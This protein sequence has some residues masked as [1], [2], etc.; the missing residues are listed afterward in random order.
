MVR[1]ALLEWFA[2]LD[3]LPADHPVEIA[4]EGASPG[5]GTQAVLASVVR[6]DQ[7]SAAL[8]IAAGSYDGEPRIFARV[9]TGTGD[10]IAGA[11]TAWR[12]DVTGSG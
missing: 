10:D 8:M 2:I 5:E 11:A 4:E 7:S 12:E 1:D 9:F 3:G 6:P